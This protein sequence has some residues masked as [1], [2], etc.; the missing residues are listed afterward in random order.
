MKTE[1]SARAVLILMLMAGCSTSSQNLTDNKFTSNGI[2]HSKGVPVGQDNSLADGQ[3]SGSKSSKGLSALDKD[4]KRSLDAPTD[5][6]LELLQRAQ[7]EEDAG[8]L[9]QAKILYD[10]V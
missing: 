4:S 2:H 10:A 8:H 6:V 3:L 7:I 1:P 5:P 9:A